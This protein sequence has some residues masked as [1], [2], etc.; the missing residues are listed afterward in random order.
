MR[1]ELARSVEV[2]ASGSKEGEESA[3]RREPESG[4]VVEM[5]VELLVVDVIESG[6]EPFRAAL[7]LEL[8][9]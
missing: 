9:L 4:C 5:R 6:R 1:G 3:L 7:P 8:R 2:N